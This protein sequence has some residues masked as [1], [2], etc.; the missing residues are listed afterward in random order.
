MIAGQIVALPYARDSLRKGG[1]SI[2]ASDDVRNK[3]R[4]FKVATLGS[5]Q[6][7]QCSGPFQRPS[8]DGVTLSSVGVT[9]RF[10]SPPLRRCGEFPA[11]VDGIS[12]TK[13]QSLTANG[14]TN[15]RSI[16]GQ[17]NSS[18]SISAS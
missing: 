7:N 8:A 12:D 14:G 10:G 9:Q 11:E 18:Q 6:F 15:M 16:S 2:T 5:H 3:G 1:R 17:Q 4:K 13:I